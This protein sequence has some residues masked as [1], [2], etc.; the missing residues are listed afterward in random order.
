MDALVLIVSITIVTIIVVYGLRHA[1]QDSSDELLS[2]A[3]LVRYDNETRDIWGK[4][5]SAG[6]AEQYVTQE[7]LRLGEKYFIFQNIILPSAFDKTPFTEVDHIV[8][9]QFGVF[10]I[11]TKSHKGTIYGNKDSDNWKQYLYRDKVYDMHNPLKQNYSH[12]EALKKFLGVN[13]KSNIHSYVVFP[14]AQK[15]KVNSSFVTNDIHEIMDRILNHR[16]LM[17]DPDT[18]ARIVSSLANYDNKHAQV[19]ASHIDGVQN[20]LH[21]RH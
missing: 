18:F 17:Y 4:T 9:S 11:E 15:V 14:K 6:E 10:C 8:V 16:K 1:K 3:H 5:N 7:L 12:R 20:Y 19:E 13:L 2:N 21:S